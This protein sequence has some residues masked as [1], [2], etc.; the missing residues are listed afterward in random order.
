MGSF[1]LWIAP[2]A[3]DQSVNCYSRP[4]HS[5]ITY[6]HSYVCTVQYR[7]E[8][9]DPHIIGKRFNQ[10]QKNILLLWN[11]ADRAETKI[12]QLDY[13]M[14]AWW[15]TPF[16]LVVRPRPHSIFPHWPTFSYGKIG[17]HQICCIQGQ[18]TYPVRRV[19]A[20]SWP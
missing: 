14:I 8:L 3:T 2:L 4:D 5:G 16:R 15:F 6:S 19:S 1:T 9:T 11:K 17:G 18:R 10:M 12:A 20:L 7:R 13:S